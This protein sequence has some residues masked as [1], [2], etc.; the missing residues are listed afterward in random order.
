MFVTK[1]NITTPAPSRSTKNSAGYDLYSSIDI[2]LFKGARVLIGTGWGWTDIPD[3][4][5]GQIKSRSGMA[6]KGLDAQAGVIDGDYFGEF[7]VLVSYSGD[8]PLEIKRGDRIA[9]LII[10]KYLTLGEHV[11]AERVGGFGSTGE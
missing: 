1:G 8:R 5:Y 7:K 11:E 3:G 2:K 4:V 6:V 10:K 9:Q